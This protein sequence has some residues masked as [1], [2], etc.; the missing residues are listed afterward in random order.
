MVECFYCKHK[1]LCS[2][3]K[4]CVCGAAADVCLGL[5]VTVFVDALVFFIKSVSRIGRTLLQIMM[6][7]IFVTTL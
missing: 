3:L 2:V 1:V 5:F 7:I 4:P 6:L